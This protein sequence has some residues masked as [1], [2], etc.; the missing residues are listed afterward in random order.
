MAALDKTFPT[1]DCSMCILAPKVVECGRHININL[2]ILTEIETISGEEGNFTVR[3]KK[4]PRYVDM[5]KCVGCGV[6]AQKCPK[7]VPNE[8]NQRLDKRKAIYVPYAQAVPL[9][10]TIDR[11]RYI[12]FSKGIDVACKG[13]GVCAA[14]CYRHAININAFTDLQIASQVKAFWA[15]Q[16]THSRTDPRFSRHKRESL[17]QK[18]IVDPWL[19]PSYSIGALTN[20]Q[21]STGCS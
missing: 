8:Y 1:N 5:D 4:P 16:L 7:K 9:K 14:T 2:M 21:F 12:Y 13:C 18:S 17:Y 6:C 11:K 19:L 15:I 3:L 10:Y 20:R